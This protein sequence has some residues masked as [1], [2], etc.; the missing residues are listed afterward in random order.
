[1]EGNANRKWITK[2]NTY[3]RNPL[4]H[5]CTTTRDTRRVK[6]TRFRHC[7]WLNTFRRRWHGLFH[8]FI[9][10]NIVRYWQF[11]SMCSKFVRFECTYVWNKWRECIFGQI[12]TKKL[13]ENGANKWQRS[14]VQL[15]CPSSVIYRIYSMV[16]F[17]DENVTDSGTSAGRRLHLGECTPPAEQTAARNFF[18][19]SRPAFSSFCAPHTSIIYKL[20]WK[21]HQLVEKLFLFS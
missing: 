16:Y 6:S 14:R 5:H 19:N 9:K 11:G 7:S 8:L 17:A 10:W 13:C 4:A 3:I 21:M 15:R 20:L 1:M 2:E 12:F 18:D